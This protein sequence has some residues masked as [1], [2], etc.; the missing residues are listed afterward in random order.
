MGSG[1]PRDRFFVI[2]IQKCS[3]KRRKKDANIENQVIATRWTSLLIKIDLRRLER[4]RL[5]NSETRRVWKF[6]IGYSKISPLVSYLLFTS[7]Q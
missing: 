1:K 3:K 5:T 7:L 4:L 2:R 6:P